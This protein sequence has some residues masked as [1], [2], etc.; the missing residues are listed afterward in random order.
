[1]TFREIFTATVGLFLFV[2]LLIDVAAGRYTLHEQRLAA[3]QQLIAE[4]P[5]LCDFLTARGEII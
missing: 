4:A 1:M 5:V 2:A 3:Q